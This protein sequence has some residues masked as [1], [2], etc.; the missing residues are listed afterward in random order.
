MD[1]EL[2][3]NS[4]LTQIF[5]GSEF[6]K[7]LQPRDG[8]PVFSNTG[9]L[10]FWVDLIVRPSI[11]SISRIIPNG[12]GRQFT[13]MVKENIK[14][15]I[16]TYRFISFSLQDSIDI[17]EKFRLIII[18]ALNV[19]YE[20]FKANPAHKLCIY[21]ILKNIESTND[22]IARFLHNHFTF[23]TGA[24]HINDDELFN[25]FYEQNQRASHREEHIILDSR[26]V[27]IIVSIVKSMG[28][29]WVRRLNVLLDYLIRNIPTVYNTDGMD[30]EYETKNHF[31]E[32]LRLI[33]TANTEVS[34]TPPD[35]QIPFFYSINFRRLT[36]K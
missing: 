22:P 20:D 4:F 24:S 35:V 10:N 3:H 19:F 11:V 28:I 17:H 15:L 36:G 31:V 26:F 25:R 12:Q 27:N 1:L 7:I 16:I 8:N 18:N 14:Q 6:R 30:I 21:L 2:T 32:Y 33:R 13:E 9:E 34:Y 5:Q 29:N 23:I